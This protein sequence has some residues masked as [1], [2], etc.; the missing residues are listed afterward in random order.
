VFNPASRIQRWINER[1]RPNSWPSMLYDP[2]P[3]E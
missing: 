3:S 2:F 1:S